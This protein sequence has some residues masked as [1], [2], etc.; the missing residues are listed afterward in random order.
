MAR[1][2]LKFD[3]IGILDDLYRETVRPGSKWLETAVEL[4]TPY[5]DL[6]LGVVAYEFDLRA[7][8]VALHRQ[9]MVG[10]AGLATIVRDSFDLSSPDFLDLV[11]R[12]GAVI[13]LNDVLGAPVGEIPRFAPL[14]KN[15]GAVDWLSVQAVDTDGRGVKFDA[16]VPPR[17]KFEPVD[18]RRWALLARHFVA[19]ARLHRRLRAGSGAPVGSIDRRGESC[20]LK[21]GEP[22]AKIMLEQAATRIG[23]AHRRGTSPDAALSLWQVLASE[24]WSLVADPDSDRRR[25]FVVYENVP[26]APDPRSLSKRERVV[27][28]L[29]AMGN[30][31]KLIAYEL[32]VG[33][34]S[35]SA[36]LTRIRRK[37]RVESRAELV[38]LIASLATTRVDREQMERA[39]VAFSSS[40][41]E[42]IAP[43]QLT[44]GELEV[45][46]LAARGLSNTAIAEAR[47]ARPRTVAN[48]LA[49]I[50]RKLG[51]SSRA[52]LGLMMG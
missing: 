34:S 39:G 28:Q 20:D 23:S 14:A 31:N 36:L 15:L 11:Y 7:D 19:A 46:R 52:Q 29:A 32:G 27:A 33:E 9:R 10:D 38:N 26:Y 42:S 30:S 3:A 45:A 8:A 6:G 49:S 12:G 37:L 41:K 40:R 44:R 1:V 2:K 48:Q 21:P 13:T 24:R 51:I 35:V 5:L 43:A 4:V 50:Y 18:R 17:A 22:R 16:A 25:S 47:G